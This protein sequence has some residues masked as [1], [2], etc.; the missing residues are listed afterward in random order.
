MSVKILN[1]RTNQNKRRAIM[2]TTLNKIREHTLCT[3]GW[4]KLL[5]TLGKT[6][7]DD[8]P[9][10]L[11]TILDSNGLDDALWCLRAVDSHEKEMRLFAVWCARQVQHLMTDQRSLV[12]LDVAE[13]FAHGEATKDELA[14][15]ALS[16]A[17]VARD[18][19][20]ATNAAWC[21]ANAAA[22]SI[23]SAARAPRAAAWSAANAAKTARA[24]AGAAA[25]SAANDAW[26]AMDV[27]AWNAARD[28]VRDAVRDAQEVKFRE[29][30]GEQ[31]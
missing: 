7:A 9:L 11:I 28:A 18:A 1:V 17:R 20:D 22:W 2:N 5:R 21:A 16:A 13:R 14:A 26:D 4:E 31:K 15:A 30:F 6:K 23:A 29:M 10:S 8:E 12:A 3:Y 25:W 27:A 24:A 19:M